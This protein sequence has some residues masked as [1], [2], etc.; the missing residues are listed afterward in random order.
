MG[1]PV[2]WLLVASESAP[3]VSRVQC[4]WIKSFDSL[5]VTSDSCVPS[6]S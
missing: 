3:L 6:D 2:I 5:G 4:N 1:L